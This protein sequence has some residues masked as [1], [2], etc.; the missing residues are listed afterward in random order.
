MLDDA[1]REAREDRRRAGPADGGAGQ[2]RWTISP[3]YSDLLA[4]YGERLDRAEHA[5]WDADRRAE[6]VLNGLGLSEVT[7]TGRSDRYLVASVVG[8]RW[9]RCWY[10]GRRP[11]VGRARNHLDDTAAAFLEEELRG[12]PGVVVLAAAMTRRSRRRRCT[13][14]IDL[15]PAVG[16]PTRYGGRYTTCTR[17]K[18][19]RAGTLAAR[20][21]AEEQEELADLR[22]AV[23]VTAHQVAP[24]RAKRDNEK[25]GYGHTAGR[26]Q[27]QISGTGP[28][29]GLPARG[30]GTLSGPQA[31]RTAAVVRAER[32]PGASTSGRGDCGVLRRTIQLPGRAAAGPPG[33][34]GGGPSPGHRRE[35][36]RKVD[37]VGCAGRAPGVDR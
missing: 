32:R 15:D 8:S 11:A 22:R 6:I 23:S 36:D 12:L 37:P 26:V 5:A 2:N 3:G 21:F 34:R 13:D 17:R 27:S 4:A 24:G 31:A 1:L 35:R 14:L 10:A 16:G 33:H 18:A 9:R 30:T 25:M 29:R 19:G 28:Q 7:T 20:R